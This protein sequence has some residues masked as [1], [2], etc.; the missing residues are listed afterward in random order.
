MITIYS[1]IHISKNLS[2]NTH[3]LQLVFLWKKGKPKALKETLFQAK[4]SW[5]LTILP[6]IEILFIEGE[7]KTHVGH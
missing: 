7:S 6:F 3:Y 4:H 5:T 1:I 2:R